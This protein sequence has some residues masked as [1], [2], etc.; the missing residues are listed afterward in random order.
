MIKPFSKNIIFF[1]TEFTSLDPNKSEIISIGLVK[2]NGDELY[3]ELEYADEPSAWVKENVIPLLKGGKISK[4][5]AI[6][7]IKAFIGDTK[8]Y[9]VGYINQDDVILWQKLYMSIG[10]EE[11]IFH[12]VAIDFSTMLFMYGIDPRNYYFGDDNGFL[13]KIGIDSKKYKQHN[14]LDD[15]N[16]LREV[17]IK[18]IENPKIFSK[19]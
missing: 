13:G 18:F 1:D 15:A 7:K 10:I 3:L 6:T 11:N 2:P 19:K 4:R 16:L 9:I 12:L 5:D 17:Y 8:P 14:A